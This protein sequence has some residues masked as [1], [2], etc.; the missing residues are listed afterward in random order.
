[1]SSSYPSLD[2]TF[3]RL[4]EVRKAFL[5][6]H[7]ALLN[8][9]RTVYEQFHGRIRSNGEFFQLVINHDW[10]SWLRPISQF[11]AEVDEAF[12]PKTKEPMT[13][14]RATALLDRAKTFIQ[15]D[16]NGTIPQK[17]YYRAIQ[18]DP[19]IAMMHARVSELL[20]EKQ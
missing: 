17:Q 15:P 6:L 7:K 14:E 9:E 5:H 12:D 3:Q 11:I 8:S 19:D 16:L 4:R 10:F 20:D 13:L 2:L 18:R 1:M